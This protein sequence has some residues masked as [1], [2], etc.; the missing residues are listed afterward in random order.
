MKPYCKLFNNSYNYKIY[1]N[2]GIFKILISVIILSVFYLSCA[3]VYCQTEKLM[4][5]GSTS[6]QPIA[7][8]LSEHFMEKRPD[9]KIEI[10]GGGSSA[11]VQAALSG[12]ADIGMS[13][14][15]LAASESHLK[16]FAIAYD[17]IVMIVNP[18]NHIDNISRDDIRRIFAFDITA[19][20]DINASAGLGV[21]TVL[22]REDGSGTR[23]AFEELIMGTV[24]IAARALVQDSTGSIREI[25]ANDIDAIGYISFGCLN[26]KVRALAVDGI[27]P[28]MKNFTEADP[29]RKYRVIRPFL[30]LTKEEPRGAAREFMDYIRSEEGADIIKAEGLVPVQ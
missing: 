18:Q 1:F 6:V 17:A 25:V 9:I 2:R 22:T 28:E 23:G 12:A 14:R 10:Q 24:E 4:I 7:E 3:P 21:I 30:F 11:G 8:K 29:A 13:S 15:E 27:K 19:W 26:Q 20:S 5:A 16:T